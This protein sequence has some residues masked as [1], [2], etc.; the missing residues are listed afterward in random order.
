MQYTLKGL[1]WRYRLQC[2]LWS[3]T[4]LAFGLQFVYISLHECI[5][6]DFDGFIKLCSLGVALTG[7]VVSPLFSIYLYFYRRKTSTLLAK[8]PGSRTPDGL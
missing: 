4:S 6:D 3:L 5:D 8:Q 7:L 1:V 2:W